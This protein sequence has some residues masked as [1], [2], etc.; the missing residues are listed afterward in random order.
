MCLNRNEMLLSN[1]NVIFQIMFCQ[2]T[3]LKNPE[4]KPDDLDALSWCHDLPRYRFDTTSPRQH[5]HIKKVENHKNAFLIPTK[6]CLFIKSLISRFFQIFAKNI[7]V[8]KI[9]NIKKQLLFVYNHKVFIIIY[10]I[11]DISRALKR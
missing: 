9:I 1:G 8:M 3:V 11:W 5:M 4:V 7:S 6:N 10:D 2:V